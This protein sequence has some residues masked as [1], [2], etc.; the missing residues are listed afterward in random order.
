MM[1]DV[2]KY[3]K[4][5]KTKK[6]REEIQKIPWYYDGLENLCNRIHPTKQMLRISDIKQLSHD[7]KLFRF[8]SAKPQKPLAP[9]RAG[10]YMGII[11]EINGVRTS[12][13]YSLVSSP[14]QLA[15][16]EIGIRKKAGGFVSPYLLENAKIGDV[17][18]ATEPMGNLFYNSLFHGNNLVFIA[19]G[20]GIT[21]F[22]SMI[23]GITE[24]AIPL[25]ICLI[26]GALSKKDILFKE[27]LEDIQSRRDNVSINYVLSEPD[28]NW[29]GECGF[30]TKDIISK[31]VGN[32]DDKYFYIVG[33]RAMYG[34]VDAELQSLGVPKHKT[35][36]EAFGVP[37]D[38]TQVM[39]WPKNIELGKK[40]QITLKFR[41]LGNEEE[42]KFEAPSNEPLLNSIERTGHKDL[43][44]ENGCRSGECALCRTKLVTGNVFVPPEVTIR[45]IDRDYG[46]IHPCISYPI[47]D[48]YLDLTLT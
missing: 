2:K 39:G 44:I 30:I 41:Q 31:I 5:E 29:K 40:V 15:Y 33:N 4:A 14:N 1:E 25:N 32:I 37:E 23:R 13:P 42:I 21:P 8:V 7:T 35:F 45:D 47:T 10:Q 38:I 18:E 11:V 46:F 34:F 26:Y 9:F 43:V 22:I 20:C 17:I 27:E 28:P 19:G 12:R 36:F 48:L 24:K 16:Y 6:K 3:Q